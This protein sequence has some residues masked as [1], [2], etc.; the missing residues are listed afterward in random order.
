[1]HQ[2]ALSTAEAFPVEASENWPIRLSLA[3]PERVPSGC[4]QWAERGRVRAFFEG[5]LFDRRELAA[6]INCSN[7]ATSDSHII[8]RAY[9]RWGETVLSRLRGRFVVVIVDQTR[10]LA[11]AARDPVG[12]HPLFYVTTNSH[13]L[14]ASSP[15]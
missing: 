7:H 2:P 10:R 8:L 5:V 9:E 4:V 14:F 15:K 6:S 1:M 3:E 11:L 13:V 12:S